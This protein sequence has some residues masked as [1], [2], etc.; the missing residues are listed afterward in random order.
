MALNMPSTNVYITQLAATAVAR[1][2]N[3][4]LAVVVIDDTEGSSQVVKCTTINDLKK[5]N[6]TVANYND[7][8]MAFLGSPQKILPMTLCRC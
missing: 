4:K 3:G 8:G 2:A 5:D 6:Y 7:I 1:S